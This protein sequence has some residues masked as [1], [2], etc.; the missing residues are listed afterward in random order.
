[1]DAQQKLYDQLQEDLNAER[2]QRHADVERIHELL[3]INHIQDDYVGELRQH[4]IDEKPPPPPPWPQ[5]LRNS[6]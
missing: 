4:I 3:K 6:N 1:M 5:A 2:L